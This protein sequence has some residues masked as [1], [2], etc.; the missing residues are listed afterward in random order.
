M[1]FLCNWNLRTYTTPTIFPFDFISIMISFLS[2]KCDVF[3]HFCRCCYSCL[4]LLLL[5]DQS[6]FLMLFW[7]K[8]VLNIVIPLFSTLFDLSSPIFCSL[9]SAACVC[10]IEGGKKK[11]RAQENNDNGN[12]NNGKKQENV[13][14]WGW[15]CRRQFWCVYSIIMYY[16]LIS[17]SWVD[18]WLNCVW[19]C[20]FCTYIHFLSLQKTN[21]CTHFHM[22]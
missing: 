22:I 18:A 11:K 2:F 7:L 21:D 9:A 19:I 5:I 12:N 3:S 8:L 4:R 13:S 1:S 10:N 20:R 17:I 6:I 14:R 16:F 15:H